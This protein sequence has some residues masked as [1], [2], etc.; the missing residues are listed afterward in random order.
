MNSNRGK[1]GA[2]VLAAFLFGTALFV[3][4]SSVEIEQ[5]RF[6]YDEYEQEWYENQEKLDSLMLDRSYIL[7]PPIGPMGRD[8]N[9]DAGYRKD[10]GDQ[11]LRANAI[12]PGE[13]IDYWPGRGDTGKLEIT[14]DEEDWYYFGV[15]NG[16][17]IDVTLTVPTDY[18]FDLYLWDINELERASS[19]NPGSATETISYTA[20]Y[21]G[22]W[23]ISFH[24]IDGPAEAQYTFSVDLGSQD[25]ANSGGDA[26]DDFGT[27]TSIIDGTYH[28]YLDKD[29]D[30]DW[31]QFSVNEGQGIRFNL[32]VEDE[33]PLS[34]FDV[35]LYNPSGEE[36]HREAYYG[37][38]QL[39]IRADTSG[40]WRA[41]VKIF[42][43]YT[44]IPEPT[45]WDYWT[46]GSGAYKFDFA[47]LSSGPEP[48]EP[49]P[50]PDITTIAQTF[51][52]INGPG[53]NADEYGYLASIPACN[54]MDGGMRYL[55]PIVYTGDTTPTEWYGT[56]DDTTDYLL[57]DWNTYLS[58]KGRSAIEYIVPSDPIEAA[59]QIATD[60]WTSSDLAVVAV[61]GTPYE[62]ST[63]IALQKS[64][65]LKRVAETETIYCRDDEKI[66]D[67]AGYKA[68]V[69]N[70]MPKWGAINISIDGGNREPYLFNFFPRFMLMGDDWWPV[71][72]EEKYDIYYPVT[73]LGVWGAGVQTIG[74]Q[75]DWDF[76]ITKIAGDRYKIKIDDFRST[77]KVTVTTPVPDDLLVILVDPAGH[78]R[79]PDVPNWNGG[80]INP[81]HEWNG[82]DH[83]NYP[84]DCD[85]WR[86]WD[87]E[88]HTEFSAEVLHPEKGN[89]VAIVVPRY[90][91]GSSSIDY[92]ITAEV[93]ELNTKRMS[94][95]IS[96]ANAAVIASQEHVPLL[97]VTEDGVPA[98]TQAA[99]D[100][101]GVND[102]IFVHSDNLGNK[103]TGDLPNVV[104][105][106]DSLQAIVDHIKDYSHTENYI[107]ITSLKTGDGYF[108]PSA[109]IAAYHCAPVLQIDGAAG[110]TTTSAS[111][112][113]IGEIE[114]NTYCYDSEKQE[115]L[116]T[117]PEDW[118]PV[119]SNPNPPENSVYLGSTSDII[120]GINSEYGDP[121]WTYPSNLDDQQLTS[122]GY[123]Y[124]NLDDKVVIC[125]SDSGDDVWSTP[126]SGKEAV[127]PASMAERIDSWRNWGGDYYHGNRAPGHLPDH[128]A[129]IENT[130]WDLLKQILNYLLKGEGELPPF[131]LDAK[132]YWFEYM[133]DGMYNYINSLGLDLFGREAY[134]FVAPR[135]DINLEL[136]FA[137][138]GNKSMA[139]HI[140]GKTPAYINDVIVR[141]V[142]YPALIFAN[143]NRDV[144]TTQ[145]MNFPDGESWTM[146]NGKSGTTYAT[147]TIK[148]DF[149][150]HFR[151]F[152]GHCLWDAHIERMNEGAS[153]MYYSGHGTGGS[154][155]SAVYI[156]N[157]FSNYPE[158][159]WYDAWRSYMY[160]SWRTPRDEGRRWFN[161]EPPNLY[162]IVHYKWVDQLTENLRSNAIFYMSCSTAQQFAPL[163]YLDHGAVLFYGNAGSGLCPQ[164]DLMDDYYFEK[165]M[166]E[167]E[168]IGEAY[169]DLVWLF[170]RDFTTGDPVPMYGPSSL[171]LTTVHCI[172]GDPTLVIYSPEWTSPAS[173]DAVVDGSGNSQPYAPDISGPTFG[174]PG[175]EYE[176][177]FTVSDPESDDV[178]LYVDWGDGDNEDYSG[179]YTS[180]DDVVLSH[181]FS[182]QG[183][184]IIKAKSKDI[185]DSEG[186]WGALQ[187]NIPR[188]KVFAFI[189]I[190]ERII[191]RFPMLERIVSIFPL[192][193]KI[194]S[195]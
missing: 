54:Y 73:T 50:Q 12:Y 79:A 182:G 97:Y 49:I 154:G 115:F 137:M 150:S 35:Y 46:Y 92:T 30:E 165:I 52:V 76:V 18:D 84:P 85:A 98:E 162:D 186:P 91:E 127:P 126:V 164:E 77:L 20:D 9:D 153:V 190:L 158:V 178:Y 70:I 75:D 160:D 28:A 134:L 88:P 3:P 53:T 176:F 83:D 189:Q 31:Y 62:D 107:T 42:P 69:M 103:V 47:I 45:E 101:L 57:D 142:L 39:Y 170:Q 72:V 6:D 124:L 194:T 109:Y 1:I 172:Y 187:I 121:V 166:V 36:V 104:H 34:D 171:Q 82:I 16:M 193:N 86:T 94:A 15:C 56:V 25:D 40:N 17:S 139:G 113:F 108:A 192:Y 183:A 100:A 110:A 38:D 81:I 37:D 64:T 149:M 144:T 29:D 74:S 177:T 21:T 71:H 99:F 105:D 156:Q 80:P 130:S 7:Y 111:T 185:S 135:E 129:P 27:A 67:L 167:G 58:S 32:H 11:W 161:P 33:A 138:M 61:D 191:Q 59:A 131:G 60:A 180:G 169:A 123:I 55:A 155:I 151:T 125:K 116:W 152:D 63:D 26:G 114:G 13:I 22:F 43:G 14:Y 119:D 132:R 5:Y 188:P 44:D 95:A 112:L 140:P 19:T 184:Y 4:V 89:W 145:A 118:V 8:N 68:Y 195:L 93:K 96:A 10:A 2:V 128:N 163:V 168:S 173:I 157:E 41:K 181:T 78:V 175:T 117:N 146:N 102:V 65:T 51:K 90:A 147:R 87:P 133:H 24:F 141:N 159:I 23:Y 136:H 179:P 122:S 48:P 143:P 148:R 106:L 66:T 174:K 120:Y